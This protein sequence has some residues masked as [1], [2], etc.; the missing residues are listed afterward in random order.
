MVSSIYGGVDSPGRDRA[1][2]PK[3]NPIF[4]PIIKSA[5]FFFFFLVL[6]SAAHL[7]IVFDVIASKEPAPPLLFDSSPLSLQ[8]C[9]HGFVIVSQYVICFCNFFP[10]EY[11]LQLVEFFW[12]RIVIIFFFFELGMDEADMTP[13]QK[14]V[15]F[16]DR[17]NDGLIYPWETY[18]GSIFI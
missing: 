9:F 18:Q 8:L 14:H 11:D 15:A 5:I 6:F 4:K 3:Q 16:F 10:I 2:L 17:N 1:Q 7:I 13:L 12:A